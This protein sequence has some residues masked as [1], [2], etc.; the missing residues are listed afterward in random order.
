MRLQVEETRGQR[1][2]IAEGGE[3]RGADGRGEGGQLTYRAA[4]YRYIAAEGNEALL[5]R[6]TRAVLRRATRIELRP[7][8][9]ARRRPQRR[10]R[11]HRADRAAGNGSSR[12]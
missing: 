8:S 12:A 6:D 11:L 4:F 10:R 9:S 3:G 1:R 5:D 7:T 2:P